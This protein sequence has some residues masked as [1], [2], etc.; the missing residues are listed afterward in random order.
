MKVLLGVIGALS[1][2]VSGICC[3]GGSAT[4]TPV[5]VVIGGTSFIASV[6]CFAGVG[7]IQAIEY[8]GK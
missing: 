2:L 3:V 4:D 7:I 6:V 1:F 8:K 5:A